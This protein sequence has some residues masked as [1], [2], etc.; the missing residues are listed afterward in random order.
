M[1]IY[2]IHDI[3]GLVTLKT[4]NNETITSIYKLQFTD[5]IKAVQTCNK[6]NFIYD[7]NC[8]HVVKI[9]LPEVI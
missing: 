9:E 1:V 5:K 6:L 2:E 3:F 4:C 8:Y 7:F